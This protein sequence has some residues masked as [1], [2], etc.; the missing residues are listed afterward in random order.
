MPLDV[1]DHG[2]RGGFSLGDARNVRRQ[3]D[4]RMVPEGVALRQRLR[5]GN[6]DDGAGEMP[7]VERVDERLVFELS[8]AADMD[9][10]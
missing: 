5:L 10:C 8:A 1:A 6:V 3:Q 4:L 9:E 2:C 7:G